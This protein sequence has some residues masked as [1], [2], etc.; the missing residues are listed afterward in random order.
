MQDSNKNLRFSLLSSMD[1][2]I[3]IK[4]VES[5]SFIAFFSYITG[6]LGTWFG[7]S[8]L[9]VTRLRSMWRTRERHFLFVK[10]KEK[11]VMRHEPWRLVR[12]QR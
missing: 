6:C 1:A 9:S 10:R 2:D 3:A 4:S 12:T 8:F 11:F 5:M 7:L